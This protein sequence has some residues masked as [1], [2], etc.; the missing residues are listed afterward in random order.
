VA[1]YTKCR[2]C[3]GTGENKVLNPVLPKGLFVGKGEG[4]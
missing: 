3:G 2:A 4:R 1:Y